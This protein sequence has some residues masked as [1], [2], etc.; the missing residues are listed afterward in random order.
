MSSEYITVP[1]FAAIEY[2][3]DA[4]TCFFSLYTSPIIYNN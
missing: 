2:E 1:A 3:A 4:G